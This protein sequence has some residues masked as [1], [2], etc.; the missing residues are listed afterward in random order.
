MC[1]RIARSVFS[2]VKIEPVL[3]K[4]ENED[5]PYRTANRSVEARVDVKVHGFWTRQQEA[6]FDIRVTHPK[7]QLL[8]ATDISAQLVNN[9]REKKRQ[10]NQRIINIDRGVFTPLI[11]S[12]TGMIGGECQ[13]FLRPWPTR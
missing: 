12:T 13:L 2:E 4:F 9:E 7:A 1:C 11:F 6:F 10:Y 8:T 3:L 5:L